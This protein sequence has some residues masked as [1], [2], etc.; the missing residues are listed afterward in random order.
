MSI[1]AKRSSLY[2]TLSQEKNN[3][4]ICWPWKNKN[5]N[6]EVNLVKHKEFSKATDTQLTR[7]FE[8]KSMF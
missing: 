8:K 2:P 6:G 1:S 5:E 7:S 3:F 4:D